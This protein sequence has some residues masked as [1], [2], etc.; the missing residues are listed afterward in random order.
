MDLTIKIGRG[1]VKLKKKFSGREKGVSWIP[2]PPA[3][4]HRNGGG[5]VMMKYLEW[6]VSESEHRC[7]F[8]YGLIRVNP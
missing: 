1:K 4:R 5:A 3:V 6:L 7:R 8:G 2:I